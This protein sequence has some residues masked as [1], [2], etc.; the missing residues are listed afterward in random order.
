MDMY[1]VENRIAGL[2]NYSV[3]VRGATCTVALGVR[4]HTPAL[5]HYSV[6][7]NH[8]SLISF[9]SLDLRGLMPD[10][11]D[12]NATPEQVARMIYVLDCEYGKALETH[13]CDC[14]GCTND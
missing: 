11:S 7:N 13:V 8:D 6:W 4:D 12:V 14:H 5:W 9:G 2:R 1:E 10:G 3:P